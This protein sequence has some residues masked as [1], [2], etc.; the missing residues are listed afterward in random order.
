M[1]TAV[2]MPKQGQSVES[3]LIVSWKK[4]VGDAVAEGE[5]LC[6]V[7]T[8]KALLEVESPVAGSVLAHFFNPGDEVPVLTPIAAVGEPGESTQ[9]LRPAGAAAAEPASPAPA[10]AATSEPA[11]ASSLA[12]G[13]DGDEGRLAVS[14]RARHLAT[15]QNLDLAA[16]AGTGPHGR[17]IERDVRAALVSPQPVR[18]P[19]VTPLARTML[20][21]GAFEAPVRGSGVS[22][23]I[24]AEDLNTARPAP[25]AGPVAVVEADVEIIPVKGIRK[26]IAERM[27]ASLQTTAQLTLNASADAR[28][29]QNYRQRLKTSREALGL[30]GV[31]IND[32]L[33]FAVSRMLP[34]FPALNALYAEQ[35][36]S[37]YRHVHLAFAVDTPRGLMVPVIRRADS[38]SLRQISQESRRLAAACLEGTI[39]PEDLNGG[40]FTVTNLGSFGIESFTPVLNPPQVAILGVSSI[41]LKPVQVES[42][43]Q[44]I[45]HLGLS[46]TINHQV[47]DGAPGA[48]FLQ[49]LAEGL[50]QFELLLAL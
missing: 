2:I 42:E 20:A 8:D 5:T 33:L 28:A 40:T 43:V 7:E 19:A 13:F 16:L 18:Q 34:Q 44:F 45:P 14:P 12:K 23:R 15:G 49:T 3:C 10:P 6:E 35:Q 50:A 41:Q 4:N 29:L 37:Q 22:G 46:L 27:L 17:I 11:G 38:L 25:A 39:A 24:M 21:T 1:A 36:I 31:T 9:D 30:Q 47:V 32:L 26:V 48:K